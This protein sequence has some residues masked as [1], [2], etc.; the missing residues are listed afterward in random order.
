MSGLH[1]ACFGSLSNVLTDDS[2]RKILERF[3]DAIVIRFRFIAAPL[4]FC[5]RA[6]S[7]VSAGGFGRKLTTIGVRLPNYFGNKA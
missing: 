2:Y 3:S 6:L 1:L 7:L 4:E 5:L